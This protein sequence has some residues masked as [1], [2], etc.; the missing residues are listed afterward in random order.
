V[1]AGSAVL[2]GIYGCLTV[3]L[4]KAEGG[5]LLGATL[6]IVTGAALGGCAAS[7]LSRWLQAYRLAREIKKDKGSP[8]WDC[9]MQCSFRRSP[10]RI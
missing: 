1:I 3:V 9:K 2:G 10:L 7:A 6:I 5:S 8:P 4:N